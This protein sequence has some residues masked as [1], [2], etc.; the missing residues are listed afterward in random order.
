M[1]ATTDGGSSGVRELRFEG[2]SY[3]LTR[4]ATLPAPT[5]DPGG[6]AVLLDLPPV[7]IESLGLPLPCPAIARCSR[8]S[9]TPEI[10]GFFEHQ[11]G[12]PRRSELHHPWATRGVGLVSPGIR[13]RDP[14]SAF[15][16]LPGLPP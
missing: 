6:S 11:H 9:G 15:P 16:L 3:R 8:R 2:G 10:E 7:P 13:F 1:P 4:T 12:Y 5:A 14:L